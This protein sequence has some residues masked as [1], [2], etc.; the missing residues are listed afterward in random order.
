MVRNK[1]ASA[2]MALIAGLLGMCVSDA[3][4]ALPEMQVG[5]RPPIT[6]QPQSVELDDAAISEAT[7]TIVTEDDAASTSN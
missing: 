2:G 1:K 3:A 7:D 6:A 4:L 5:T